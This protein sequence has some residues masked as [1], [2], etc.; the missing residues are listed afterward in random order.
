METI[1]RKQNKLLKHKINIR[2]DKRQGTRDRQNYTDIQINQK[3]LKLKFRTELNSQQTR[4]L[5]ILTA[6]CSM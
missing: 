2:N 6:T 5:T 4:Y 3:K 1:L